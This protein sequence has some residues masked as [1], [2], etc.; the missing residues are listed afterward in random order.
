MLRGKILQLVEALLGQK[1]S[2]DDPVLS[3]GTD[4]MICANVSMNM[5]ILVYGHPL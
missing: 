2:Q 3:V 1:L 5:A 4:T